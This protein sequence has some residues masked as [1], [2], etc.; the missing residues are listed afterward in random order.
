MH[1]Y[2]YSLEAQRERLNKFADY[3]GMEVVREYCD[4]GCSGKNIS[5]RPEFTQML[6]NVANERDGVDYILVFKLSKFGRNVADV[7]NSLQYIQDSD[8]S[9]WCSDPS[10]DG[11]GT[12]QN[13][14]KASNRIEW[15]SNRDDVI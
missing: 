4:A 13:G 10:D 1:V 14:W 5:G 11:H 2:G 12:A 3:Q 15:Q 9:C 6:K 7:L 8:G